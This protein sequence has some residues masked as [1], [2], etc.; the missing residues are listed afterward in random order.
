MSICPCCKRA[1]PVKRTTEDKRLTQDIAKCAAAILA[2]ENAM[3]NPFF[4]DAV[5][6]IMAEAVR[7]NETISDPSKLWRMYRRADKKPSYAPVAVPVEAVEE[8]E[9]VAA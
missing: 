8:L 1:L 9:L 2:C 4:S 5:D 3:T 7:L 6:A